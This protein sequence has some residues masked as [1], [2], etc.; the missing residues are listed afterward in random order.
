MAI[1]LPYGTGRIAAAMDWGRCLGRLDIADTAALADPRDAMRAALDQPI[2]LDGPALGAFRPGERV[3]IIVSDS[4]RKTGIHAL[5]PVLIDGLTE[6]GIRDNDIQFVYATGT[7]RGPTPEE[8]VQILGAEM[9]AR[10]GSRA[11]AHDPYDAAQLVTVGETSRGTPVSINRRVYESDRIIATGAVVLHYFGGFGGG[12]KAVVPGVAGVDTISHNHALNLDPNSDQLDPRVRIGALDGN[13]VAEDMLEAAQMVPVDCIVNTV[14][15]RHGQI[16]GVFAGGMDAAH[17]AAA[18]FARAMF[19][20][21]IAE[22]ADLVIAASGPTKNW[23]QTHKALFN[24]YQAVRPDGRIVLAARCEEGLGSANFEK[25]LA[26]G[27]RAAIIAGLR[28]QSEINGQT[29][30][31]TIEKTPITWLV[32]DLSDA[33]T[34]RLGAR[35]AASL[36]GALSQARAELAAAGCSNPAYYLMPSAAYS[37]PVLD[38]AR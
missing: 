32:T 9:H 19:T 34:A 7:H 2:G 31:S 29:A 27:D 6:A 38:R 25:W 26:L 37:V 23:V 33:D 8:E 1:E 13:P 12:R 10:F 11:Y 17:R 35:K 18:D 16:A 20:V 22:R 36:E 24:A 15:N 5:L 28:K 30:L 14:L 4:F 3:A 21:P